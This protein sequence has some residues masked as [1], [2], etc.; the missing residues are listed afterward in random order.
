M[1]GSHI[2]CIKP[3]YLFEHSDVLSHVLLH[4]L[5]PAKGVHADSPTDL[6]GPALSVS[7]CLSLSAFLD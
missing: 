3:T 6:I 4:I 7:N 1:T 5:I 2:N